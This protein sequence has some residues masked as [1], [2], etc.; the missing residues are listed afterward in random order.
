MLCFT[1]ASWWQVSKLLFSDQY[2]SALYFGYPSALVGWFYGWKVP[3]VVA[4]RG[5][6]VPGYNP[7]F[8]AYYR[9]IKPM[10]ALSW[11]KAKQVVANSQWLADLAGNTAQVPIKIIPNGV[12]ANLFR[13]VNETRK[14]KTFTVTAGGTIPGPKKGLEYLLE[15]FASFHQQHPQTELLLFGEGSLNEKLKEQA[16]QLGVE[17]AV[18]FA[19]Q[20]THQQLAQQLPRC[21]VFCLPSLAE[22]MSNAMLEA[23]ACGLPIIATDVGGAKEVVDGNGIIVKTK[24]SNEIA[25]A[26]K[27][28]YAD[29]QLRLRMSKKSR[30]KAEK[31]GWG[32]VGG[33]YL[34]LLEAS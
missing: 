2:S 15:G 31:M 33:E 29:E 13:S 24:N 22:G 1:L 8:S 26:L 19:G 20:I 16:Q 34:S 25:Q 3:Y 11:K 21:H 27:K 23:A 4:L 32:E 18:K 12:D 9:L 30:E 5:A 17:D 28:I 10:V 14:F 6:D 7:K